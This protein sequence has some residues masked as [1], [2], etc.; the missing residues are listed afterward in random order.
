MSRFI[1]SIQFDCIFLSPCTH[2]TES[3]LIECV[4]KWWAPLPSLAYKYLL[5]QYFVLIWLNGEKQRRAKLQYGRHMGSW[6]TLWET[7]LPGVAPLCVNEKLTF[8]VSSYWD[9]ELH[10]SSWSCL[11]SP[12]LPF[13]YLTSLSNADSSFLYDS[14]FLGVLEPVLHSFPMH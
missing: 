2:E 7:Y 11:P 4:Q 14:S 12:L 1:T 3:W 9:F 6:M 8:V 5:L 10:Y 13:S